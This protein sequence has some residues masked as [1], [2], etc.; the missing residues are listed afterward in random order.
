MEFA[1]GESHA[2]HRAAEALVVHLVQVEA[3]LERH[4]AQRGADRLTANLQRVAGQTD[5]AHRPG[6]V[7]L[8]RARGPHVVEQTARTTGAVEAGESEYFAGDEFARLVGGH[9]SS[10]R[11]HDHRPG[12]DGTQYKTREHAVTP[13]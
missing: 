10:E 9:R 12:R 13:T 3:G 7:E 8:H 2:R 4:A 11:R 6:A 5:V 1:I